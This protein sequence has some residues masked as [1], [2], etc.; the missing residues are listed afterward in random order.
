LACLNFFIQ[1]IIHSFS[2]SIE[3]VKNRFHSGL[4]HDHL[5]EYYLF[6]YNLNG[7]TF[8][9]GIGYSTPAACFSL[10][11]NGHVSFHQYFDMISYLAQPVKK[12]SKNEVFKKAE[13]VWIKIIQQWLQFIKKGKVSLTLTAGLDSRIIL[14]S[15]IKTAYPGIR[16]LYFRA[17]AITGCGIR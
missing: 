5:L 13:D 3:P 17:P 2:D 6:N 7:N 1:K 9:E 11:D 4:A 12:L 8:F 14:G 15:F 16:D 10:R